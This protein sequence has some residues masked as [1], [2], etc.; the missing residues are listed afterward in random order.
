MT[1]HNS[2]S[3]PWRVPPY[4]DALHDVLRAIE[5]VPDES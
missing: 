2:T 3:H 4:N 5:E 1:D